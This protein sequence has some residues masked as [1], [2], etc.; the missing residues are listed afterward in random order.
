MMSHLIFMTKV[1]EFGI[2]VTLSN[3]SIR[4]F[5]LF[6]SKLTGTGKI[7][8]FATVSS[9]QRQQNNFNA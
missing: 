5:I 7:V 4:V 3:F 9:L 1:T 8:K 2:V 6:M